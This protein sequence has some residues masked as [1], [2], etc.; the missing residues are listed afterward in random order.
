MRGEIE[1][2]RFTRTVKDGGLSNSHGEERK[3]SETGSEN[4]ATVRRWKQEMH[5]AC[6]THVIGREKRDNDDTAA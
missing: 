2:M 1:R 3:D 6:R 5:R 4:I